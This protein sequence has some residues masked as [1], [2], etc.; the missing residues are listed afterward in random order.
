MSNTENR[1]EKDDIPNFR[2]DNPEKHKDTKDID[3]NADVKNASPNNTKKK[4]DINWKK[5][6]IFTSISI[7]AISV[8]AG[9][10]FFISYLST[11]KETPVI[12]IEQKWERQIKI[13]DFR[14]VKD[15]DWC[16][17]MPSDA[18]NIHSRQEIRSYREVED[19]MSCQMV[20]QSN[21]DG[22]SSLKQVCEQKYRK[23]PVYEN[24][25][26]YSIDRWRLMDVLTAQGTDKNP[27]W[28]STDHLIFNQSNILGNIRLGDKSEHYTSIFESHDED[29][30]KDIH[31]CSQKESVWHTYHQGNEY[32]GLSYPLTGI[33]CDTI[34][35]K[36]V[37]RKKS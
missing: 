24:Y 9:I 37:I 26:S 6:G 5:I 19:G 29:G 30:D 36:F 27:T 11:S 25:C 23:T 10:Y 4:N 22:T 28:P 34:I 16:S 33:S 18:Y 1:Y 3:F 13:E 20:T 2:Y 31:K 32:K 35:E 14:V 8:I 7:V 15:D 12:L 21:G 17:D